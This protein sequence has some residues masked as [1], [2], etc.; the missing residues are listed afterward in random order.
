MASSCAALRGWLG[1][2]ALQRRPHVGFSLQ[3]R[4]T[5]PAAAV[6]SLCSAGGSTGAAG[7]AARRPQP[8]VLGDGSMQ[9]PGGGTRRQGEHPGVTDGLLG[10]RADGW[11]RLQQTLDEVL[12]LVRHGG[13]RLQ[14][15][16]AGHEWLSDGR[17]HVSAA[18]TSQALP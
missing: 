5:S 1:P 18:R 3:W 9:V 11:V 7:G 13:P 14:M 6:A 8:Q 10:C 4:V 17:P 2:D 12:G 16:E 15:R